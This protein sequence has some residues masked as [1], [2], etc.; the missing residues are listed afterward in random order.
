MSRLP[1]TFV[2]HSLC[3][4]SLTLAIASCTQPGDPG[5]QGGDAGHM[6]PPAAPTALLRKLVG[7]WSGSGRQTPLGDFPIMNMDL[8]PVGA[9]LLFARSDLDADNNLRFSFDV[10]QAE[11]QEQLVFRNGGY[12]QSILRDTRAG[13]I[14]HSDTSY[15]FC[16]LARG[17]T[18][19][20]AR[21][22]FAAADRIELDVKVRGKQH[23]LWTAQRIEERSAPQPFPADTGAHASDTSPFPAMP[24][25][26]VRVGWT[27]PLATPADVWVLLSRDGCGLSGC[28]TSRSLMAAVTA[29]DTSV[30]LVFDQLHTGSYQVMALLDRD[31]SFRSTLSPSRGDGV[32]WP[33]NTAIQVAESG[34]SSANLHVGYTVP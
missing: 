13:L 2:A 15:R 3:A 28:K 4:V 23:L 21:W 20:D 11:G 8:R 7:L 5:G 25:L 34:E 17:C 9:Y 12:F 6:S 26:R 10:E 27:D 31:R 19:L 30:E 18:Y 32:T 29:G 22:T 33:L 14:E 1:R 24:S 16:A